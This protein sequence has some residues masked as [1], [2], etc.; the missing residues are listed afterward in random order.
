MTDHPEPRPN[1]DA[2]PKP[3]RFGPDFDLASL[4]TAA[5]AQAALDEL[6]REIISIDEQIERASARYNE[7]GRRSDS[8]WLI[9][10]RTAVRHRRRTRQRVQ[11]RWGELRRQERRAAHS[12]ERPFREFW[13]AA[14]DML[15]SDTFAAIVREAMR[16]A[17]QPT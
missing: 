15:P 14:R 10:A 2:G 1:G 3:S 5:D 4:A 13:H 16:R 6:Q 11:E 9:A 7:T 12:E 17:E 8:A